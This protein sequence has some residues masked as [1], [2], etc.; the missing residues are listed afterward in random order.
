MTTAGDQSAPRHIAALDGVRGLAILVV[1]IHNPSFIMRGSEHALLKLTGAITAT[2]WSGVQLFFVLSGFLIT[3]ILVDA[4]GRDGYFRTFYI[5]RTLRIFPLYYAFLVVTF[6]VVPLFADPAW[7]RTA[8]QN[9]GWYWAYLANWG[10]PFGHDVPGLT[11]FWSLAVEEQFYLF[12]PLLV[13][14][15]P[16]RGMIALC[17]TIIVLS[18]F[19]RF[20]LHTMGLPPLAGYEFTIA[21]WD[22]LAAGALL[23]VLV[24]EESSRQWLRRHMPTI[25]IGALLALLLFIGI[26]HGFH[27]GE[28]SVQVLG[29]TIV[30][31]LS[32]WL[33]YICLAPSSGAARWVHDAASARWLRFLGKYSYAIYVFHYPIHFI[34]SHHLADVVNGADTNWRLLRLA[35]YVC[36]I[37][38]LS[39][40]AALISWHVLEKP[41]LDFKERFAP[42]RR[43]RVS[44]Y[45]SARY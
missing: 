28:L 8:H 18:P 20:L 27:E 2:G 6:L 29:Q 44:R 1:L 41:F 25:G 38:V 37:A 43:S 26:D 21:R 22:A 17:G 19:V 13:L 24:R 5:R 16:R 9:Q 4:R 31:I 32:A 33:I 40:A 15:L 30:S 35:L 45:T 34:A 3:G 7:V 14:A 23:A 42:S 12:W 36:G 11:H 10:A 39:I